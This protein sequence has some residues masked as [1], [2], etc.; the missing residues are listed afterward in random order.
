M[1][2]TCPDPDGFMPREDVIDYLRR[3]AETVDA[4]V[5]TDTDVTRVSATDSGFTVETSQGPYSARRVVL[6]SGAYPK[7]K[8]PP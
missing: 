6:A 7:P 3:Y 8:W 2:Y 1:P 5:Q 4:P